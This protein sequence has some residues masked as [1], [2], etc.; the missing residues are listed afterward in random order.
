MKVRELIERLGNVNQEADVALFWDGSARGDVDGICRRGD[1]TI[2]LVGDWS[3]YRD[4]SHRAFPE[5]DVLFD[6]NAELHSSECS[7]AE[8]R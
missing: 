4:G 6:A 8:R 2:V 3:I 5:V 7:E 1:A